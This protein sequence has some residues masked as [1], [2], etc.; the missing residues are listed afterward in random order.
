MTIETIVRQVAS[1]SRVQAA[2]SVAEAFFAHADKLGRPY[3]VSVEKLFAGF[4]EGSNSDEEMITE[5][6][7]ARIAHLTVAPASS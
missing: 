7:C 4:E 1:E 3:S 5:L 2:R 6:L